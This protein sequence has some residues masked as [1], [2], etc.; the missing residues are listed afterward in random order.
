MDDVIVWPTQRTAYALPSWIEDPAD[1]ESIGSYC[2]GRNLGGTNTY[3]FDETEFETV[4]TNGDE[5][6]E[7]TPDAFRI[8][9]PYNSGQG[10][11]LRAYRPYAELSALSDTTTADREVVSLLTQSLIAESLSL[12]AAR[13]GNKEEAG[14]WLAVRDELRKN[15]RLAATWSRLVRRVV[16]PKAMGV[17][18]I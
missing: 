15:E 9:L 18:Y 16:R 8:T 10:Y 4:W 5:V 14:M 7:L 11:F 12:S 6:D 1:V 3:M 2:H 17:G 13:R